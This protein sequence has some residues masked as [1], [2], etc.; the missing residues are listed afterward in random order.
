MPHRSKEKG[1]IKANVFRVMVRTLCCAYGITWKCYILATPDQQPKSKLCFGM[2]KGL[3]W[4][5]CWRSLSA[6]S[7]RQL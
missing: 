2:S 5:S 4:G 3:A 7:H 1:K 6:K